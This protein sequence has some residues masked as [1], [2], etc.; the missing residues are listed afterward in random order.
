MTDRLEISEPAVDDVAEISETESP[1]ELD[2]GER[3]ATSP[4]LEDKRRFHLAMRVLWITVGLGVAVLAL[5]VFSPAGVWERVDRMSTLVLVP[6][7]TLLGT[8]VGWY[9]GGKKG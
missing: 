7:Q 8:A 9:F 2:Q 4:A 6:F 1:L 5:A 3:W